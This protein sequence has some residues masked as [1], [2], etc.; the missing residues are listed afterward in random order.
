MRNELLTPDEVRGLD[1]RYA[2]LFIRGANGMLTIASGIVI[3]FM[4]V[5]HSGLRIKSG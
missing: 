2:I 3:P 1:N 4:S 5:Y